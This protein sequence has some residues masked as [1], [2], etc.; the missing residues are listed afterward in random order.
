MPP[1]YKLAYIMKYSENAI[2]PQGII[3]YWGQSL[4]S[5]PKGWALCDGTEGTPDLQNRFAYGVETGENPGEIGGWETHNHTYSELPSHNH[6]IIDPGHNHVIG[7]GPVGIAGPSPTIAGPDSLKQEPFMSYTGVSVDS[8]GVNNPST[9]NISSL[10]PYYSVACIMKLTSDNFI[11]LGAICMWAQPLNSIPNVWQ[12]CNGNLGTVDLQNRFLRCVPLGQ[13]PGTLGGI[14]SPYLHQH[15]FTQIPI[16]THS[17]IDPGHSHEIDE[18]VDYSRRTEASGIDRLMTNIINPSYNS[19]TN[20][21]GI[22]LEDSGVVNPSTDL[23][24]G[25]PPYYRIAFIQKIS[26]TAPVLSNLVLEPVHPIDVN[27]LHLSYDFSDAEGDVDNSRIIWYKNNMAQ[28]LYENE[29][30]VP[31]SATS[32]GEIWNASVTPFDGIDFGI[33]H[34][35][36]SITIE[37]NYP[38]V[39]SNVLITPNPAYN[40]DDLILSYSFSDQNYHTEGS[41]KII[42]Y[43]N[44]VEQPDFENETTVP[45]SATSEGEIWNATVTPNDGY[46][47]GDLVWSST[48]F[49]SFN[50]APSLTSFPG[51]ITF[52][53]MSTGHNLVWT[54]VDIVNRDPYITLTDNGESYVPSSVSIIDSTITLN[55]DDLVTGVY[56]FKLTYHDGLGGDIEDTHEI[57]VTVLLTMGPNFLTFLPYIIIGAVGFAVVYGILKLKEKMEMRRVLRITK[58]YKEE[59]SEKGS[60]FKNEEF[61]F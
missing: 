7:I 41:T 40:I 6:G 39:V 60:G 51:N 44:N 17:V 32:E 52:Q 8:F 53:V 35:S 33:E 21:T 55:V 37:V 30:T 29:T 57:K 26:N 50:D 25:L 38:P 34:F 45:A 4:A 3:L 2:I 15:T 42:W 22:T 13:N 20:T 18:Y 10:P 61:E 46:T 54:V 27:D 59:H 14:S 56:L 16:H 12:L 48:R 9:E 36:T 43:C 5:I 11:P 47:Y 23:K 24:N 58:G 31:A 49:I 28:P 19:S 1:Y